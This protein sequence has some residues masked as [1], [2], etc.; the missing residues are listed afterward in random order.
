MQYFQSVKE[1]I[2]EY[3]RMCAANLGCTG[4][5]SKGHCSLTPRYIDQVVL[6]VYTWAKANPTVTN[7]DVLKDFLMKTFGLTPDQ[8][9]IDSCECLACNG[10]TCSE[11]IG[12][13]HDSIW[14][15]QY[16]GGDVY[17][18]AESN[19]SSNDDSQ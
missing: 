5:P 9:N 12:S 13:S 4:C 14:D 19:T 15:K 11:C 16:V 7:R 6:D 2:I 1:F 10:Q 3:N 17:D 8:I 18:K